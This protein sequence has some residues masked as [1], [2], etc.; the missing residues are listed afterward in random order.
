MAGR[1]PKLMHTSARKR[2][3]DV[4][5]ASPWSTSAGPTMFLT[6]PSAGYEPSGA[7]AREAI[8]RQPLLGY[9]SDPRRPISRVTRLS[10][11]G[12]VRVLA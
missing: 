8:D 3:H 7:G 11:S 10:F 9:G 6:A 2:F 12:L 5:Q 1:K 4:K